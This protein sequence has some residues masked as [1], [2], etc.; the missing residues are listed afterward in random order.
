MHKTIKES[1]QY[2]EVLKT[3]SVGFPSHYRLFI[4]PS[5]LSL[6]K[7]CQILSGTDIQVG[8]QN[9]HWESQGGFTG[10]VSPEM[11]KEIG[12]QI[13]EIGHADRRQYFGENDLTVNKKVLSALQH[14]LTPL[15]CI[16]EPEIEKAYG[17]EKEYV[18]RQVLIALKGVSRGD[19][20]KVM[21][22]YEPAWSIGESGIPAGPDYVETMHA[23]IRKILAERYGGQ[24]AEKVPILYGGSVNRSNA[25][26]FLSRD[27][28]DG[29]FIGRAAWEV[30]GFIEII[31]DGQKRYA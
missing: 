6:P 7:V 2:A 16:G 21:L 31:Q 12:V 9:M 8:A 3:A 23:S 20:S 22:A 14:A 25:L 29:L 18:L 11:I 10:E 27:N 15:I 24:Q 28:I 30:S 1:E 26:A 13:V 5:F 19:L 4:I 17:V